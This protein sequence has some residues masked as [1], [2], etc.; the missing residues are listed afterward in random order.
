MKLNVMA[1]EDSAGFDA[2]GLAK[3]VELRTTD[4]AGDSRS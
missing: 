2:E 3:G 4:A 1:L